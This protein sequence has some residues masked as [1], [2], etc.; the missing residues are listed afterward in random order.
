M[1]ES[2]LRAIDERVTT[3]INDAVK[4]ADATR[5]SAKAVGEANGAD[6]QNAA[7]TQVTQTCHACHVV[8]RN[9]THFKGL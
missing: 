3:Q 6:A 8:Y 4:F 9:G 1:S 2:A 7:L 5:D